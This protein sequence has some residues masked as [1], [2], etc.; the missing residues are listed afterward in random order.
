MAMQPAFFFGP[1][2]LQAWDQRKRVSHRRAH[3]HLRDLRAE[4]S[5][6]GEEWRDLSDSD[7][8]LNYVCSRPD[9][10][11]V[12]GPGIVS[13]RCG[14]VG[15]QDSNLH[16][17]R[18]DFLVTVAD[19]SAAR[20]HPSSSG[21]GVPVFGQTPVWLDPGDVSAAPAATRG[22]T[23]MTREQG[24]GFHGIHQADTVSRE[25]ARAYL[26]TAHREWSEALHP[27]PIFK[28]SLFDGHNF[29]WDLY[30]NSTP[31]GRVMCPTVLDF[32]RCWLDPPYE[33]PGFYCVTADPQGGVVFGFIDPLGSAK[34]PYHA[35][36]DVVSRG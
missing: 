36:D 24:T 22:D 1:Q 16:E 10:E 19:G 23:V 20:L 8:L 14:F 27:R 7:W 30:L 34:H 11:V 6:S 2:D 33:R 32:G 3:A 29:R 13:M 17:R 21:H 31:W 9:A 15:S 35:G 18:F 25:Q 28:R 12:V 4:M 5:A 26:R